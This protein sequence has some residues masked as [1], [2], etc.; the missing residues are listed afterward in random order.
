MVQSDCPYCQASLPFYR[1]LPKTTD[2]QV[3][4]A[5]PPGDTG[6]SDYRAAVQPD[7]VVFPGP[8][9]LPVN[10]TPT[11]LLVSREGVVQAFWPG[12]LSEERQAHVMSVVFGGR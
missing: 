4:L 11:L 10:S 6:L 8:G 1:R 3:V 12:L 2:V 9:T 7:D 5:A